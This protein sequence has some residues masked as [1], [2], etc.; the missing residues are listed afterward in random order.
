MW[1]ENKGK[2][3][4]VS[5]TSNG[6]MRLERKTED[7]LPAPSPLFFTV[8]NCG[9]GWRCPTACSDQAEI[10]LSTQLFSRKLPPGQVNCLQPG[11]SLLTVTLWHLMLSKAHTAVHGSLQGH[12][13][14][15]ERLN[16]KLIRSRYKGL[17][18]FVHVHKTM[19]SKYSEADY[20]RKKKKTKSMET[21]CRAREL[22][23]GE[24][25]KKNE[26]NTLQEQVTSNE[27]RRGSRQI[28]EL[29]P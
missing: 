5:A 28:S 23:K 3:V 18:S 22:E 25:R 14:T 17:G 7:M 20:H 26:T 24:V 1:N 12:R 15:T 13:D 11:I 9:Q 2:L 29:L 6:E 21:Q 19:L 27:A 4:R 16:W 8:S 10:K